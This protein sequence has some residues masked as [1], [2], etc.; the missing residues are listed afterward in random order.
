MFNSAS[1]RMAA[2]LSTTPLNSLRPSQVSAPSSSWFSKLP[3]MPT[4]SSKSES[5]N[6]FLD[7]Q[8][9][10][11][12]KSK[13]FGHTEYES[14][15]QNVRKEDAP[16][17]SETDRLTRLKESLSPSALKLSMQ[18]T[19]NRFT[20]LTE[21]KDWKVAVMSTSGKRDKFKDEVDWSG[22]Q[23]GRVGMGAG[24]KFF[25]NVTFDGY[26]DATK[27]AYA[28]DYK[29]KNASGKV[30]PKRIMEPSAF[31]TER[32]E[33][34]PVR[35]YGSSSNEVDLVAR[36]AARRFKKD[37]VDTYTKEYTSRIASDKKKW[38]NLVDGVQNTKNTTMKRVRKVY[39]DYLMSVKN[40]L[41]KQESL[42]NEQLEIQAITLINR[43]IPEF[44]EGVVDATG[45]VTKDGSVFIPTPL[46]IKGAKNETNAKAKG[47]AALGV[48]I[49]TITNGIVPIVSA[50]KPPTVPVNSAPVAPKPSGFTGFF[51]FGAKPE[52]PAANAQARL[53]TPLT[54]ANPLLS[55]TAS[56]A[57]TVSNQSSTPA[58]VSNQSSTPVSNTVATVNK[59]V[60]GGRRRTNKRKNSSRR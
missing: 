43:A 17:M 9:S 22:N 40:A 54:V 50:L 11:N 2:P 12:F 26:P 42:D 58:T 19:R 6:P 7:I 52:P 34:T 55:A 10:R 56:P 32:R 18:D 48:T 1:A 4:F 59:P 35:V 16:K 44:I 45:K 24:S 25:Q 21:G 8:R 47:E 5:S 28:Q 41:D 23:I 3:S 20:T 37:R 57:V 33:S 36:E 49:E 15:G 29:F 38:Q 46:T 27:Y 14:F 31:V 30:D 39:G 53:N 13:P 51:S 60:S